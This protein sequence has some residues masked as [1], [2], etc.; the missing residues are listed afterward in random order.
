MNKQLH[1]TDQK[2]ILLLSVTAMAVV[3]GDIGTSPLYAMKECFSGSHG[4]AP[5]PE[6]VLGVLSLIIWTLVFI[7]TG[8]YL[9]VVMHADN[10]GTGGILALMSLVTPR[11][12]IAQH[13]T[14]RYLA[15]LGLFGAALLYGEGI[16][17]PAISVL[18]AVE[19]FAVISPHLAPY[20]V[21]LALL[22]LG[23]L[24]I[25]QQTGPS[26]F[27][28]PFGYFM[29]VWFFVIGVLG[30]AQV[31]Q[32]P[33][34][35]EAVNPFLAL[36]FLI[37]SPAQALIV[38]GSVFLVV[39]GAEVL[40]VDMEQFGRL[41]IWLGWLT[42]VLP[43]LFFN[44]L[45]QGAL[46]LQDQS[47]A[48]NPF[49]LLAPWWF[50]LPLVILAIVAAIIASQAVISG[51]FSLTRQAVQLGYLPRLDIQHTSMWEIGRIYIPQINIAGFT[52][53]IFL[54]LAFHS[55]SGLA[56]AYGISVALTMGITTI[57]AYYVAI[58]RWHWSKRFAK[59]LFGLFLLM[60]IVF[61]LANSLKI[62][63]GGWVTLVIAAAFFTIM[64]TWRRGRDILAERLQI[65]TAPVLDFLAGLKIDDT[66]RVPGTAVFM[67]RTIDHTPAALIHNVRHN[68][69]VHKTVILLMV[70]TEEL[71]RLREE[72]RVEVKSL[73]NGFYRMIM[74][75]GFIEDP[76]VPR[77][78][79]SCNTPGLNLEAKDITYFIGREILLA[80]DMPGM[81]IW[82]ERLFAFMSQ[83]AM[84]ATMYYR[85]PP[86]QVIEIGLQVE[87]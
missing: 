19:G 55:T 58:N 20:V 21:T 67:S 59:C 9:S 84:R 76:D 49:F 81:A 46:L 23:L 85:I 1:P 35:W 5:T 17:T 62:T 32:T 7:V 53:T 40:Y 29:L 25:I 31:V 71:P 75:F 79:K 60:D 70:V 82:R 61:I 34:V 27:E 80:T 4:I 74:R 41:P 52:A 28:R 2:G 43:G 16:I 87:L 18:S 24:F 64:T 36:R 83:N 6:N 78:L 44:Y 48:A 33:A 12:Q 54:V 3:F 56:G 69:V 47:N 65:Q 8:K 13:G 72:D 26:S 51:T 86:T 37:F 42:V 14:K 73:G 11:K 45:G 68:K 57:L 77:V 10:N 22:I 66:I 30:L 15:L 50:L 38:L 63:H 39:T